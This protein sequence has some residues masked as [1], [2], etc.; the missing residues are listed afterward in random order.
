MQVSDPVFHD[1]ETVTGTVITSTNVAAV[2]IHL[3]GRSMRLPRA[4]F[5]VFQM[6]YTV[7][8]VPFWLRKTYTAQV[9]ALSSSGAQAE[10]DVTISVR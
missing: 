8:H 2:E 3:A 1:G 5:G 9:V 10:R 4:D 7:P 6:T